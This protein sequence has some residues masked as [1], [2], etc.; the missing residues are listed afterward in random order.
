MHKSAREGLIENLNEHNRVYKKQK[1]AIFS[2]RPGD[3]F[4]DYSRFRQIGHKHAK[5]S[6][7]R[8]EVKE[9]HASKYDNLKE[10]EESP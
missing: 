1:P 9:S 6:R 2:L 5:E 8:E 7:K 4:V 10:F 3:N